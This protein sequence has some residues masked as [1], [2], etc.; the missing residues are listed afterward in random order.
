MMKKSTI[1]ADKAAKR[2]AMKRIS[3]QKYITDEERN[4]IH[5]MSKIEDIC[6]D[7]ADKIYDMRRKC[8]SIKAIAKAIRKRDRFVSAV[9]GYNDWRH[10]GTCQVT[11]L[12]KEG[13]S[14]KA[15]AKRLKISDRIVARVVGCGAARKPGKTRV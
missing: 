4:M 7:T 11:A 5:G 12:R 14:I 10:I 9:I 2:I 8:F 1:T 3:R 6:K 13:L 15:I